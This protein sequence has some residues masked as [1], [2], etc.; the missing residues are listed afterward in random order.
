[1]IIEICVDNL[2]SVEVCAEAGADRVELCAG[3]A[4]G[5]TTP[6]LGLQKAARRIFPGRIMTMIRPRGGDFCYSR[7]EQEIMLDDIQAARDAGADGVVFGCLNVDGTIDQSLTATLCEATAGLDVTFHRAFDVSCDLARSL[8]TLI[9]LGIPRVLTSGG[10]PEMDDLALERIAELVRQARG[11]IT[12]L[13]GG[14]IRAERV[15]EIAERTGASEC[16]FPA[17]E[18]RS[19]P[20]VFRRPD[21][22]MGSLHLPGEYEKMVASAAEILLAKGSR[23]GS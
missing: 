14:G 15:P 3:L 22:P 16:H 5:G 11:R 19:S 8:E 2:A 12:I 23:S 20:M 7:G 17:R 21:I 6:S 4:E 9:D 13:P 10:R 18:S 1:M